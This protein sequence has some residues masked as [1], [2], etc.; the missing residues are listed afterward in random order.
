MEIQAFVKEMREG[1]ELS[2]SEAT[3]SAYSFSLSLRTP[4]K[5]V[6]RLLLRTLLNEVIVAP[7]SAWSERWI[8][9]GVVSR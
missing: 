1:G 9:Q 5:G 7:S 8:S 6:R 4:G 2:S 3:L